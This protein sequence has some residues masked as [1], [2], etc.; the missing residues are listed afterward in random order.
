MDL[1]KLKTL[2]ELFENSDINE[3]EI[4]EGEDK[5]RLCRGRSSSPIVKKGDA[6]PQQA[7]DDEAAEEGGDK[8][9]EV[10]Q[11]AAKEGKIVH[12]PMVGTFYRSPSPD[13]PPFVKAGQRVEAGQTLCIIEAMKLMNQI[14]APAAGVISE[15]LAENGEPVGYNDPLFVIS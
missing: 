9:S 10:A 15:I 1:R 3:L 5:V 7:A 12:A 4:T 8:K 14:E 13:K 6:P 2:I 11:R